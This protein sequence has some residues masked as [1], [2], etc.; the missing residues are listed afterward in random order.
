M[1]LHTDAVRAQTGLRYDSAV[2][3]FCGVLDGYPVFLRQLPRQNT[4]LLQIAGELPDAENA[5]ALLQAWQTQHPCILS[6]VYKSRMMSC[7]FML[8]KKE[9]DRTICDLAA[10]AVS[11]AAELHMRPCCMSCGTE[12][13]YAPY[14]LKRNGLTVCPDCKAKLE[15]QLAAEQEKQTQM[16][17]NY[18]GL[19]LGALLGALLVFGMTWFVVR[20]GRI[21]VL[22]AYAGVLLGFLLM[23]KFGKKVTLPAA[24]MCTL[25]CL[26][27]ASCGIFLHSAQNLA[28][29]NRNV[30]SVIL[31]MSDGNRLQGGLTAGQRS[32]YDLLF[33]EPDAIEQTKSVTKEHVRMIAEN[34]TTGECMR[35]LRALYRIPIYR[36]LRS[37]SREQLFWGFLSVAAGAVMCT[38][39]ILRERKGS[40]QLR[41]P[42]TA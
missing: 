13:A 33:G 17:P 39:P 9:P 8:P 25:L 21:S 6:A 4:V 35:H 32:A 15:Q 5:N 23:K 20:A 19:L 12:D 11:A 3:A 31:L 29:T 1:R 27:G 41:K 14:F 2:R 30:T 10:A 42:V 24:G 22:T 26:L 18:A 36:T 7:L 34:D 16:N 28:Q 38:Y 40:Y 37:E